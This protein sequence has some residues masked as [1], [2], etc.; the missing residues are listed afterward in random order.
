MSGSW[1]ALSSPLASKVVLLSI[2]GGTAAAGGEDGAATG[3][4]PCSSDGSLLEGQAAGKGLAFFNSPDAARKLWNKH[5]ADI[6]V[7]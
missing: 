7:Y 6:Y 5:N 4:L 3:P 1:L 2:G